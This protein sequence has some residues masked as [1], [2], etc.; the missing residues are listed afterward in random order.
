[1]KLL[2]LNVIYLHQNHTESGQNLLLISH[3]IRLS[4]MLVYIRGGNYKLVL[5]WT[6]IK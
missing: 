6:K 2:I 3:T 5:C 1:M 4:K